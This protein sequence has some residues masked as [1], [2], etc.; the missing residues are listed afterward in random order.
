VSTSEASPVIR[1]PFFKQERKIQTAGWTLAGLLLLYSVR[2]FLSGL[3]LELP[4]ISGNQLLLFAFTALLLGLIVSI[5]LTSWFPIWIAY[6]EEKQAVFPLF[7]IFLVSQQLINWLRSFLFDDT[8]LEIASFFIALWLW[9]V[10][11]LAAVKFRTAFS[12]LLSVSQKQRP[13]NQQ[14]WRI[15]LTGSWLIILVIAGY[16]VYTQIISPLP[17]YHNYDPEY[18]YFLNSLTPFEDMDLYQRMDH[19]GTLIQLIGSGIHVLLS[20]WG[21]F[22]GESPIDIHFLEPGTFLKTARAVVLVLHLILLWLIARSKKHLESWIDL[23]NGWSVLMAYFAGHRLSY[24]FLTLWSPN[25]FNFPFGTLVLFLMFLAF[26]RKEEPDQQMQ[27]A[28]STS[29]GVIATFQIYMTAWIVAVFAGIIIFTWLQKQD[30]LAAVKQG[31]LSIF[32]AAKGYLL[33]TLTIVFQYGSYLDWVKKLIF[34]QGRYGQGPEGI[35]SRASF[36]DNLPFLWNQSQAFF[37]ISGLI[38]GVLVLLLIL[39]WKKT[40]QKYAV[41]STFAAALLLCLVL[42]LMVIKH[43]GDRYLLSGAAALPI[44]LAAFYRLLES[45]PNFR[46]PITAILF[47]LIA[48]Y[49]GNNL[50][51]ALSRHNRQDSYFLKYQDQIDSFTL[52]EGQNQTEQPR[53]HPLLWTYGAYSPCYSL[54]FGN[55]WAKNLFTEE[56]ASVCKN[57]YV[58]DIYTGNIY[59]SGPALNL[60]RLPSSTII[61]GDPDRLSARGFDQYGI[62]V[63]SDVNRLGFIVQP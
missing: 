56:I 47:L 42:A 39:S 20:P 45:Y 36:R 2:F 44:L 16:W 27:A 10:F 51:L 33:A 18:A 17:I 55:D 14:L 35:I 48:A 49:F 46:K 24:Q 34:H 15:Y 61:I 58:L 59:P 52:P 38:L 1:F 63:K 43:P 29:A 30:F 31:I 41:F 21:I 22:K 54:W 53:E 23:L 50:N 12:S 32:H 11:C 8:S 28:I 3:Q 25:S 7:V 62:L 19:P 9:I 37:L 13:A 6:L 60:D 26:D 4:G 57:Q 5:F 40:I